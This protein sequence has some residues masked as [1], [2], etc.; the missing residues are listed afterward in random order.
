MLT[1]KMPLSV[2]KAEGPLLQALFN[3]VRPSA[4]EIL[5]NKAPSCYLDLWTLAEGCWH[6]NPT[7]RL[8]ASAILDRLEML[9]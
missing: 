1:C 9:S 4:T 7:L 5:L 8:S 2:Y 3:N 6:P